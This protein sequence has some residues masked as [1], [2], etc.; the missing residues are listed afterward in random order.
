MLSK[1]Q[2]IE[3]IQEVNQSARRDWLD[4][5]DVTA[6]KRYLDHLNWMLGPRGGHSPWERPNETRAMLTRQPVD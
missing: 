2:L 1:V 3:G 6:L 5:F 4:L